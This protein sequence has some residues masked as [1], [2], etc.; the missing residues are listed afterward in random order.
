M[1]VMLLG[2]QF[3]KLEE[4]LIAENRILAHTEGISE[5]TNPINIME[6]SQ[7]PDD[8]EEMVKQVVNELD[9]CDLVYLFRDYD[10]TPA[11]RT[12]VD[13]ARRKG[14]EMRDADTL[15]KIAAQS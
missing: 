13:I 1:K 12:I 14:I 10:N 6:A 5:V 7:V 9:G 11:H 3:T 4:Y 8:V 15:T 2:N